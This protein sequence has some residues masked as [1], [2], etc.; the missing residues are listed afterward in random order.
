MMAPFYYTL[1]NTIFKQVQD[2]PYLGTLFSDNLKWRPHI[3]NTTKKVNC[4]LGFLQRN[5][6]YCPAVCK[7]NSYLALV[8]PLMEYGA[9][10]R[11]P[12]LKQDINKMKHIQRNATRFIS[13]DY[14]SITPSSVR[15]LLAKN[16]LPTLQQR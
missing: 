12:H 9:I 15:S 7:W 2:N 1:D 8:R 14:R 11:K 6:S 16:N 4:M 5:L 3:S 13:G 10:V